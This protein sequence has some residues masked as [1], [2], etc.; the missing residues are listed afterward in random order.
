MRHDPGTVCGGLQALQPVALALYLLLDPGHE[1]IRRPYRPRS[2]ALRMF[3]APVSSRRGVNFRARFRRIRVNWLTGGC[4]RMSDESKGQAAR[5]GQ[6]AACAE[7]V[8]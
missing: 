3:A 7:E 6:L 2:G 5:S 8:Y 4:V 1:G